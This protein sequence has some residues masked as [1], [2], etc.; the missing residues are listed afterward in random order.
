[1]NT[2]T[3]EDPAEA[4]YQIA[5]GVILLLAAA[6]LMIALINLPTGFDEAWHIFIAK[7]GSL[8]DLWHEAVLSG[9]PPLYFLLVRAVALLIPAHMLVLSARAISAGC[10]LLSILLFAS[11]PRAAAISRCATIAAVVAWILSPAFLVA[12]GSARSYSLMIFFI[13]AAALVLIRGLSQK[14]KPALKEQLT[15]SLLIIMALTSHLSAILFLAALI[16]ALGASVSL[17][18]SG[19]KDG[20]G[21]G[22]L[23]VVAI[24][25]L[26]LSIFGQVD[27]GRHGYLKAFLYPGNGNFAMFI[28]TA[29]LR[30][31]EVLLPVSGSGNL[32]IAPL[33]ILLGI[34]AWRRP[35]GDIGRFFSAMPLLLVSIAGLLSLTGRYPFGGLARHQAI[36]AP[37]LS[38]GIAVLFDRLAAVVKDV[39]IIAGTL[40]FLLTMILYSSGSSTLK[41]IRNGD[42][43]FWAP[44]GMME[45]LPLITSQSDVLTTHVSGIAAYGAMLASDQEISIESRRSESFAVR[46][47]KGSLLFTYRDSSWAENVNTLEYATYVKAFLLAHGLTQVLSLQIVFSDKQNRPHFFQ[48]GTSIGIIGTSL[49]LSSN[50]QLIRWSLV[51][52]DPPA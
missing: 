2:K 28:W 8:T 35:A 13:A 24:A 3:T 12:A 42:S 9:H 34:E 20:L 16:I 37:F 47:L 17:R 52:T 19:L 49:S 18:Q 1:M 7:Q 33:I 25:V 14:C 27:I 50:I 40:A 45:V 26:T 48:Q 39:R 4:R 11:T 43:S 44:D 10:A 15:L 36:I 21:I 31:A 5:L 41:F 22:W 29:L 46:H 51:P 6:H 32:L 23:A 30:E 38:A